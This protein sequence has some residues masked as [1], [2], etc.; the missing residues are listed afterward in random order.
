M[1]IVNLSL[2]EIQLSGLECQDLS[3]HSQNSKLFVGTLVPHYS[4]E[5]KKRL[6]LSSELRIL[7]RPIWVAQMKIATEQSREP[8]HAIRRLE[9]E[10]VLARARLRQVVPGQQNHAIQCVNRYPLTGVFVCFR[11]ICRLHIWTISTEQKSILLLVLVFSAEQPVQAI[12]GAHRTIRLGREL[13]FAGR[14]LQC[15]CQDHERC[16]TF[17]PQTDAW[18]TSDS[19]EVAN[20][21]T[22]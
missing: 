13:D 22:R 8:E 18:A 17:L 11:V 16:R 5:R 4:S 12:Q 9:M 19:P 3:I 15:L 2:M 6:L 10:A 1:H 21:T 7:N 20:K 14:Q